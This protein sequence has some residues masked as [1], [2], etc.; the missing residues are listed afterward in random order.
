[1]TTIKKLRLYGFKSFPKLTE[2]E[3]E[4]NFSTIIGPNGSG[5]SNISDAICFV[6]G[7]LSTKSLRA[8]KASNLIYN[9]GKNKEP[10]KQAE[11]TILFDNSTNELPVKENEVKIT[12]IVK[13]NGNSVYKINDKTVT[14]Q[15]II[16]LLAAA[17]IDPDGHNIV[18]QGDISKFIDMYTEDRREIIEEISGISIYEDKKHKALLELDKVEQKLK[19]AD[20]ILT[21][22]G[23]HLREL[24]KDRDQATKYKE[25]QQLIKD[26]KATYINV[27]IQQKQKSLQEVQNLINKETNVKDKIQEDINKIKKEVSD[28][29]D[30]LKKIN[31]EILSRGEIEQIQLHKDI[32]LIKTDSARHTSRLEFLQNEINKIKNR[33]EQ[34][35]NNFNDITKKITGLEQEKKLL[36]KEKEKLD[37]TKT[38]IKDVD[39]ETRLIDFIVR[40]ILD[41]R[42]EG[43]YGTIA[44]LGKVERKYEL[45]LEVAAGARYNAI[46]VEDDQIAEKCIK[47]LRENKLGTAI[48]LPLNKIRLNELK[49]EQ[50]QL[51]KAQGVEGVALDLVKFNPIFKNAFSYVYGNTLILDNLDSVRKLGIG[52]IRMVTLDGDLVEQSGAMIGGFRKRT[53]LNI[54]QVIRLDSD[55]KNTSNQ[56][57]ILLPE[58]SRNLAILK[59]QDKELNEFEQEIKSLKELIKKDEGSL[60][61]K[62]KYEK[63][64]YDEFKDFGQRREKINELLQNREITLIRLEENIR[65]VEQ[66]I[67]NISF[68]RA[69]LIAGLEDLQ[70]EFEEFKSANIKKTANLD[71]LMKEIQKAEQELSILGNVNLR[72]LE[73]YGEIEKEYNGLIEKKEK[74]KL[75]KQDVL[76]MMQEIETKKKDLFMKTF[77][78]IDRNFRNIFASLSTKGQAY[79]ELQDTENPFNAG[80]DIKVKIVSNKYLNIK[81]LSGGEQT[82]TALAFIFAIQ[83]YQPASFYL[84]DEVDAA[85]DKTNSEKLSKLISQYSKRAQYILISHNDNIITEAKNIYGVSMQDGVSKVVSLRI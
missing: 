12:R 17:K 54:E 74:L 51:I 80:L 76:N 50:K 14:R 7:R 41:L 46:I 13:Q 25:L 84:L 24:K 21:E 42:L 30:D 70:N 27:Q 52:R 65:T 4:K 33:K 82:L 3:F 81:S 5:K 47:Y 39:K 53:N 15:Q 72:A 2:I 49:P 16:D 73:I 85:L 55:L 10:S 1:M 62:E 66:K 63:K 31:E 29:K 35:K 61:E 38:N 68:D 69:K 37:K 83:E 78:E 28:K 26:N 18:L 67:N 9:G 60:N 44:S 58:Q 32:E 23:A 11:V 56:I 77:N 20:I 36:E 75:E 48:F 22:R 57:Q 71:S 19:E 6:L 45:A 64:F 43:V 8:D 34:L 79:L 59:D 40:K